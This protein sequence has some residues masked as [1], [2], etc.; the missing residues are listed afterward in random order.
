VPEEHNDEKADQAYNGCDHGRFAEISDKE[1]ELVYAACVAHTSHLSSQTLQT[2]FWDQ[3]VNDN[4]ESNSRN[5][6]TE[7]WP[8]ENGVKES[9]S[10]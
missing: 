2:K 6:A 7:E 1:P 8:G 5:E 3:L 9:Q 10:S 4:D